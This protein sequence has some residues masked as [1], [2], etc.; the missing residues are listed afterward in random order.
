[1]YLQ[2][3]DGSCSAG[4]FPRGAVSRALQEKSPHGTPLIG[5][6]Y[7]GLEN[8]CASVSESESHSVRKLLSWRQETRMQIRVHL[9]RSSR[10]SD[11]PQ[12]RLHLLRSSWDSEEFVVFA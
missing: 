10:D 5:P 11:V 7:A 8:R 2:L 6:V 9:L 3:S 1:M 12:I 4:L